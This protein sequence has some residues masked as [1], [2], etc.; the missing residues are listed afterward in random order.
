MLALK[1]LA[2]IL[3]LF[4]IK[5]LLGQNPEARIKPNVGGS[6]ISHFQ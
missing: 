1:H 3:V 2:P 5:K 6:F 4:N